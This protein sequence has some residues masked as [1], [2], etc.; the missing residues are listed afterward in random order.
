MPASALP[1]HLRH[2]PHED[3]PWLFK[4]VPRA[5]TAF[6]WGRP[7]LVAGNLWPVDFDMP[8]VGLPAP[9]PITSRRTWQV[10]RFPDGPWWAWYF[11]FTL[12]NG[13]HVRLGARWDDVDRYVEWPS[14]AIRRP[15]PPPL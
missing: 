6:S 9:M 3:W 4:K 12:P 7:R 14:V 8:R 11:A 5:W 2:R 15:D 13:W 10:S 1:P